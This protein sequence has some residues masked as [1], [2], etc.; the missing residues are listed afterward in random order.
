MGFAISTS[1]LEFPGKVWL[2]NRERENVFIEELPPSPPPRKPKTGLASDGDSDKPSTNTDQEK[3]SESA[4]SFFSLPLEIRIQIYHWIFLLHPV[5]RSELAL[6]YPMPTY[7]AY[8]VR[9]VQACTDLRSD[10]DVED[11]MNTEYHQPR[12]RL[13]SPYRPRCT[14]PTSLLRCSKQIYHESRE[15]PFLENEFV[16]PNWFSSGLW[17][18]RAFT[19]PLAPWQKASVRYVRLETLGRD[20]TGSS[21]KVWLRL[22]EFWSQGLRGLRLKVLIGGGVTEPT[23]SL[24]ELSGTPESQAMDIFDPLGTAPA[25][26]EE[27]LGRLQQLRRLEVEP[28]SLDWLAERRLQWCD[29]L[30]EMLNSARA[31]KGLRPVD[32]L[33]VEKRPTTKERPES[34]DTECVVSGP[35]KT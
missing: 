19:R 28:V 18:A 7:T 23:L 8:F 17:A 12:T 1:S 6:S 21:G 14:L 35:I 33:C 13:L 20:F 32:V 9:P 30:R 4:L 3:I 29:A 34:A 11:G 16:F 10:H 5:P 24:A 26:I 27:G 15:V 25:W 2:P 31:R 22:C